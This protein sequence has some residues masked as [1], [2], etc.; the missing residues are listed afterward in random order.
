MGFRQPG[1]DQDRLLK[2][3]YSWS[4]GLNHSARAS[5]IEDIQYRAGAR[6]KQAIRSL[7]IGSPFADL[8]VTVRSGPARGAKWTLFPFS[9]YWRMGGDTDVLVATQYLPEL[10]GRVFWDF[11]AHYGIHTIAM[12][13]KVGPTGQVVAFEPDAFN[14]RK[15]SRHV[16]LNR[17][18][19]VKLFNAAVS[20]RDGSGH[21]I[22]TGLGASTQHF[23][24]PDGQEK[25]TEGDVFAVKTVRADALVAAGEIR[26][27]DFIKI[28]VEGH[29]AAALEGCLQTISRHKPLILMSSHA[30]EETDGTQRL[31]APLGYGVFS[32]ANE[33][34]DWPDFTNNTYLLRAG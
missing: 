14:F 15:L 6:V 27:P 29:G 2:A 11:G 25:P 20:D 8:P 32:L 7:I 31:L 33:K 13:R 5:A 10:A 19:N 1:L 9:M 3:D 17:L 4:A 18:N 30:P 24:Y 22:F 26:P 28:D 23:A 16:G 34:L 12:A 21:M